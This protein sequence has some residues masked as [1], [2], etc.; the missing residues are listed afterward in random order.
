M[1]DIVE[2]VPVVLAVIAA[3]MSAHRAN[4]AR[5]TSDVV[6]CVL[7]IISCILLIVAQTSW[8]VSYVVQGDL[9]GTWFSNQIWL[10]FN[11]LVMVMIIITTAPR[12]WR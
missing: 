4:V 3:I 1:K 6:Y 7:A 12:N 2:F 11:T 8:W 5:R 9:L 10:V